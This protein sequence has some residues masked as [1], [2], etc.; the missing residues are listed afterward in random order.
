MWNFFF[1]VFPAAWLWKFCACDTVVQSHAPVCL[2]QR[3]LQPR[4]R[5]CQ[6]RTQVRGKTLLILSTQFLVD[7]TPV[8]QNSRFWKCKSQW[9]RWVL[10]FILNQ[11]STKVHSFLTCYQQQA[12]PWSKAILQI[13]CLSK[14]PQSYRMLGYICYSFFLTLSGEFIP[15]ICWKNCQE[16]LERK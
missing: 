2:W 11:K 6:Q 8:T 1:S 12:K 13:W 7:L 16:I 4:V 9:S 3:R 10:S 15:T 5:V 14:I